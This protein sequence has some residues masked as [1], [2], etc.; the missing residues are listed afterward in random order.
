MA[1][2]R[3]KEASEMPSGNPNNIKLESVNPLWLDVSPQ[4]RYLL[5]ED[6]DT[7]DVLMPL[8][9]MKAV[10][11]ANYSR[12]LASLKNRLVTVPRD[13]PLAEQ[14]GLLYWQWAFESPHS[15][16]VVVR[17]ELGEENTPQGHLRLVILPIVYNAMSQKAGLRNSPLFRALHRVMKVSTYHPLLRLPPADVVAEVERQGEQEREAL[18]LAAQAQ[19]L[20]RGPRTLEAC[21]VKYMF[22]FKDQQ[23]LEASKRMRSGNT[24]CQEEGSA[25]VAQIL[26]AASAQGRN[27]AATQT[28]ATAAAGATTG[29]GTGGGMEVAS[30]FHPL[31]AAAAPPQ[32]AQQHSQGYPST[33]ALAPLPP[34][35]QQVQQQQSQGYP[36]TS[37][38]ALQLQSQ[39]GER[40]ASAPR[41]GHQRQQ[42][43]PRELGPAAAAAAA[44]A[45]ARQAQPPPSLLQEPQP[46]PNHHQQRQQQQ[47]LFKEEPSDGQQQ[48]DQHRVLQA[49]LS[50][51]HL[52]HQ[53]QQSQQAQATLPGG[54]CGEYSSVQN[55][56]ASALALLSSQVEALRGHYEQRTRKLEQTVFL[57]RRS[58]VQLYSVLLPQ[59]ATGLAGVANAPVAADDPLSDQ[60]LAVLPETLAQSINQQGGFLEYLK[61]LQQKQAQ[62]ARGQ[63]AEQP[64]GDKPRQEQLQQVDAMQQQEDQGQLQDHA[65]TGAGKR[66]MPGSGMKPHPTPST[67]PVQPHRVQ[68][69]SPALASA[70]AAAEPGSAPPPASQPASSSAA[71][72]VAAPVAAGAAAGAQGQ[73]LHPTARR[74]GSG[75]LG[76][77]GPG[78]KGV[79]SWLAGLDHPRLPPR[80]P[81]PA[82]KQAPGSFKQQRSAPPTLAASDGGG[83]GEG[84]NGDI[85]TGGDGS[86]GHAPG[87]G[88]GRLSHSG[89]QATGELTSSAVA[90]PTGDG[91]PS[92]QPNVLAP[93]ARTGRLSQSAPTPLGALGSGALGRAGT[94]SSHNQ[95]GG[96]HDIAKTAGAG[97]PVAGQAQQAEQPQQ[98]QAQQCVRGGPTIAAEGAPVAHHAQQ[99]G[100][101]PQQAE[102]GCMARH[103]DASLRPMPGRAAAL[104]PGRQGSFGAPASVLPAGSAAER[105]GEEA[106]ERPLLGSLDPLGSLHVLMRQ[107]SDLWPD[108][109]NALKHV[110]S[111]LGQQPSIPRAGLQGSLPS[112][113]FLRSP[114]ASQPQQ[115]QQQAGPGQ[116]QPQLPRYHYQQQ[117][118]QPHAA[119]AQS[120]SWSQLWPA[121]SQQDQGLLPRHPSTH[122]LHQ[123]Y[124]LHQQQLQHHHQQQYLQQQQQQKGRWAAGPQAAPQSAMPFHHP[125]GADGAG[126]GPP[127]AW[128]Q[129]LLVDGFY[130]PGPQLSAEGARHLRL[131]ATTAN[132]GPPVRTSVAPSGGTAEGSMA[133]AELA[134]KYADIA[135][136][137]PQNPF[138]M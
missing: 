39:T 128:D 71:A 116:P 94:G 61:A 11:E 134:M 66:D 85:L 65:N 104:P 46:D 81:Q 32:Q 138:C 25:A 43:A 125:R 68:P 76:R 73:V 82:A 123:L 120:P 89:V 3:S 21:A 59:A 58:L 27:S 106:V 137:A 50:L 108:Q 22:V 90:R 51:Q 112:G 2:K 135:Q 136:A 77:D 99:G 31:P 48:P 36:S 122:Q 42:P 121:A 47:E 9:Y 131:P 80:L 34:P 72:G 55:P 18:G 103:G 110:L 133:A 24:P 40:A 29:G 98:Q 45:A 96:A 23:E 101:R 127:P 74:L 97:D 64:Q 87:P 78:E 19:P 60:V 16:K 10:L 8:I 26:A 95:G 49:I 111:Q 53:Q 84:A 30:A 124:Q 129:G 79:P 69:T 92:T 52:H 86:W 28:A 105:A 17:R 75:G 62:Q 13:C 57:L 7:G 4:D 44:V 114:L 109:S 35:P 117:Q 118:Q 63:Q 15:V 93:S 100:G 12:K 41:Q 5:L 119:P 113:A 14:D 67:D 91:G 107:M 37:A 54:S 20:F 70:A 132:K 38:L 6:P 88:A 126:L 83:G 102:Q 1:A 56:G 33:C 115:G 130:P